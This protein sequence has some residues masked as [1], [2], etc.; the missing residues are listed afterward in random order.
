MP[1][2]AEEMIPRR[3]SSLPSPLSLAQQRLWFLQQLNPNVPLYN[4]TEAVR[5][6]GELNV[7][8]M[9]SA[10][11]VIIDRHEV[12]R[13]TIKIIDEM[14][15]AVIHES[16][17]LRFKKID[18]STLPQEERQAEIDRLLI[19]EPRVPY[20]LVAE[21]GIRVTLL[22]LRPREHVLILMMHHIVCDWSSEG[23]IWR[24]LSALYSSLI[25]GKPVALPALPVTHGDYAAW[26][27]K[28]L[29]NTDFSADL[30][31]WEETLRGAPALLE[32]PADRGRPAIMSYQGGRIR[33]KLN[34]ALTEALRNTSRQEK[35]SLFTIFAAV[36]DTLLYRYTGSED[37]LVG[38]PLADR[39]QQE[40]Q[41][42]IGF[43]LHTHVLRTRLSANMTFR[44]L[45]GR[46]QKAVLDLYTHRAVPFDQI[47]R[48]LQPER[49][50]SYSPLF[51]V[52]LN[53]R[54]RDQQ[55]SFIGLDG[56]VVDSLM[57][58]SNTSKFD[59]FLFATDSGDE[60]WLEMEY[61]TDLFDEDRIARMLGHYQVLLEAVAA[62]PG[63][64]I[65]QVPLLTAGER[66]ADRCRLEPDGTELSPGQVPRRTD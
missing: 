34:A 22:R 49:N 42:V 60:I 38:L 30:T 57:G 53:W 13:S 46:V 54:D 9:E 1:L 61:S 40:L 8:A 52:M 23:I 51:Q 39:D 47:V 15:H 12:L 28:K 14:P 3:D 31:F 63:A 55:L 66:R 62:D 6:T 58:S 44:D 48:K 43:L 26:Q 11:N 41:S 25:S 29:A 56:L 35:T 65:A 17:P 33:W 5:L 36:L 7:N 4:E 16:W 24:E 19:E 64:N 21:P 27:E 18:L 2:A 10:F 37:I 59:L 20:D 32:L 50:L 45:L